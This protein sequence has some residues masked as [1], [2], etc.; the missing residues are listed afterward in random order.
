MKHF[1]KKLLSILLAVCLS[2]SIAPISA[3]AEGV[4]AVCKI[5]ET[6]YTDLDL[7]LD[8]IGEGESKIVE[9]LAD[10]YYDKGMVIENKNVE[11]A[12]NEYDLNIT[13]TSG[14]GLQVTNGTVEYTGVGE[15]NV[16]GT[17]AGVYVDHSNSAV[18][19]TNAMGTAQ[20][21]VNASMGKITVNGYVVGTTVGAQA[22]NSGEVEI[23]DNIRAV[24]AD[25]TGAW[26]IGGS[27]QITI[28]GIIDAENYIKISFDTKNKSDGISDVDKPGYLKYGSAGD[29]I[30][31]VRNTAC[32]IG[33]EEYATLDEALADVP[34]GGEEPTVINLLKS[35]DYNQSIVLDNK[36]ITFELNGFIL[37]VYSEGEDHPA[38]DVTNG[39]RV[40]LSGEGELNVK[41]KN[42]GVYVFSET[43]PSAVTVTSAE[44]TAA[45]GYAAFADGRASITVLE[46]VYSIDTGKNGYGAIACDTA[47]IHIKGEAI[48]TGTGVEADAATIYVEKSISAGQLGAKVLNDG[49]ITIDGEIVAP[50]YIMVDDIPKTKVDGVPDTEPG[51][52]LYSGSD[53]D[54]AVRVKATTYAL[55]VTNGAG[56]GN[57]IEGAIVTITADAAP[58]GQ[59][60]KEWTGADELEFTEG[61]KTTATAKFKMPANAVTLTAAY[62]AIP[63]SIIGVTVSPGSASV[64][65]G[66]TQGFTA[67]V[68]GTGAFDDTVVWSVTGG[69]ADT[70][71]NSSGVLT[72]AEDETAVTLTVIATANGDNSKKDTA[73]VTVTD[74]PVIK[75]ALTV[76]NGSGTGEYAEGANVVLTAATP[77]EDK[78][79]DKWVV[80]SGALDL[81]D[82]TANPIT[83]TMPAEA[84]IIAA[85]YK[86]KPADPDPTYTV[87]LNG[88]GTGATGVGNYTEGTTVNIYAGSRSSYTFTGWTSSD[89]VTFEN[90][91][92]ASTRFTMPDNAV[93]VIANWCYNGGGG[94]GSDPGSG[95][96]TGSGSDNGSGI[97]VTP[98]ASDRPNAPIQGE[99][100]VDGKVSNGNATVNFT[101]KDVAD[102]FDKTFANAKKSGNESNGITLVLKV[103]T[104]NKTINGVI[105]SFPRVVQELIINK[106]IANI[107][108]VADSPGITISTDLTAWKE[109]NKRA[110]TDVNITATLMDN[111][112]LT[113]SA[114]T[115]I[116]SRPVFDFRV[117]YGS[118][119]AV[120]SFGAGSVSV[121]IPYTLGANEKAG[122][123]QAVYVDESGKV[124][125]LISSVYDS[126][127]RVLRFSTNHF[128]TYG[129]GYK[130][131]APAF[132]DIGSHWAKDDIGFVVNR[133]LFSGTS[134]TTFSPNT[135][136]TRG[137]F[138]T[139]L[140]RLANADVSAYAK[141]SFSDV[142]SDAYYMGYI[143]WASKNSIVTGIGDGKF[144]PDQSI[145]REQLSVIM[146]N[147]AKTIGFTLPKVH[148]ENAFTD[149]AKISAYAK[150]A[151]KQMQMAGVISGK[152]GNLFDP[153]GMAT[154]AEV[155][156]VLR[157]FVELA[158][159]SDT[160][161][162]W[163]MNDPGKWMYYEN[164]KPVTGKKNI[165]GSTYTFD[166]YGVT[167]DVPKN[168]KYTAYT[169]Q[170]GDSFWLIAHR[171]GCTMSELE[172]LNNKGRF[173]LIHPGDVLRVP[174][175]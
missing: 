159:S 116:G 168:L 71:I 25:G 145:T 144:A 157:R 60:F 149:N 34:T 61:S 75:Y 96:G 63:V 3:L 26:A 129:V 42:C 58:D 89:G 170:K 161:Q 73:T 137:M 40:V 5:G 167:A 119:K 152:N 68:I 147:Y 133:R 169:V 154:R 11:F 153:H 14:I 37:N 54:S 57:Y 86:D 4:D 21:G 36:Q 91:N 172:R 171:L 70:S 121:T 16:T 23:K 47:Y 38:L 84:I 134:N 10:I 46:D 174:E 2:M 120:Q 150:D 18:T 118:G 13:N 32:A 130:Q 163:T 95:G 72:V 135:A 1:Y 22:V 65:K 48:V 41:G 143:E 126:L 151:V 55:A 74:A 6:E 110:G 165:D 83:I 97:T 132:T 166:Q 125:W 173:D 9:L 100:K 109:I 20:Y 175:K 24:N 62:E 139:A 158:I 114:K 27:S 124:Q 131:D 88:G 140:G 33:T 31:W 78:L 8:T 128:S 146:S 85:T 29:G 148:A 79:F 122:N 106:K 102:A 112:D 82:A 99:I 115:A 51:Y 113:G 43:T 52:L 117:S 80:T 59:R 160:M 104:G 98:P 103:N 138:V 30:V 92:A 87:T 17:T 39:G 93:T 50:N 164:G 123:V 15:F 101:E 44:A 81:A 56:G 66:T 67:T 77:A 49:T 7:A 90:K 156:A 35:I 105:F 107:V 53:T 76:N 108:I 94:S 111:S 64:Q 69:A 45:G 141:S 19:V 155:S 142:K 162:G 136:M 12:L 28:D 127:N